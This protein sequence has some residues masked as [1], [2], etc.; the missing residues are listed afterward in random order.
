MPPTEAALVRRLGVLD[1]TVI[2]VGS[3]V[4]AGVFVVWAPAA[5]AAGVALLI[6]LVIAGAVAI[7]NASSSAQLAAVHPESGGTYVYAGRELGPMWGAAAGGSFVVGK[8][9]SCAAGALAIGT[10]LWPEQARSVAVG[11]IVVITAVNLGGLTRTVRVTIALLAVTTISLVLVIISAIMTPAGASGAL[12]DESLVD[13]VR[14]AGLTG[15]LESAGLLFFAFAG[16]ARIATLGEEVK[17]PGTTIMRAIPLALAVV[18]VVY[19]IVAIATLWVLPIESLIESP[20]ALRSVIEQGPVPAMAP[21]VSLAA[22][23]AAFGVL[24]NLVP[25]ISRT[26]LAMAR[27]RD[28]PQW[29]SSISAERALPLRAE[30]TTAAVVILL[31]LISDLRGAIALSGVAVL[32]YYALTNAA[33]IRLGPERRR[34]PVGFA[35]AGLIGCLV[36]AFSL[37]V[38]SI[39]I[40]AT[41]LVAGGAVRSLLRSQSG[42]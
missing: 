16:Y 32:W 39:L 13:A 2:G 14:S 22:A 18:L 37:P 12:A 36:L 41:A 17:D 31:V 24:L 3:M 8:L 29:W 5:A 28:L 26:V 15:V 27:N 38:Q 7:C 40:A 9:A 21:L 30:M 20:A 34:W 35:A 11:A 42:R 6:S 19:G 10:Y 1:A 25:G 33:A 4:G 23:T